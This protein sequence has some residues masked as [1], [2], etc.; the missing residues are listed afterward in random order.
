M[1]KLGDHDLTIAHITA[2]RETMIGSTSRSCSPQLVK[3]KTGGAVRTQIHNDYWL[4]EIG[5]HDVNRIC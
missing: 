1:L 5:R 4:I 3:N 2:S